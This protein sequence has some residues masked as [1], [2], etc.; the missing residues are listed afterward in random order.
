LSPTRKK[1]KLKLSIIPLGGV[2]EIGKNMMV[3]RYADKILVVDSGLMFPE[4]EMPGVDIV[5]PDMSY[6][7]ENR[8]NVL[9]VVLTHGHED[10]IGAL[11]Y[12]LRQ[13]NAP[14]YG[15]RLTLGLV[16]AKLDEHR[17]LDSTELHEIAAGE[18]IELGPFSIEFVRISHSIP[19]GVG[20]AIKTPVGTIVH[21]GDF[22][23]DLQSVESRRMDLARFSQLGDEGT[24]LLLSDCTNVEKKGFTASES[25]VADTFDEVFSKAP[26]RVIVA[27]F[28]SNIH[29]IQQVYDTAAKYDRKVAVVGRSMAQ[30]G[31]IAE[32]LGYLTVDPEAKLSI[33]EI[34]AT[35]PS[36]VAII[37]TGSQGE[38]LS[39]LSQMALDGHKKIKITEGD[40]VIISATPIP[41]NEALVMR[42]IN[43]L[44][45][46]GAHVVYEPNSPVHVSG[47]GN[48]ED[49]RLMLSL[50]RPKFVGPVHGEPRHT[51]KYREM[52]LSMGYA[53]ENMVALTLGD[54]LE[55][56]GDTMAITG[57][58]PDFGS[59]M[60]DGIGV[61]DVSDVVLRDRRHLAQ[62][63]IILAI[64]SINS[65]TGEVAAGPDII[66]RGFV[67]IEQAEELME[68]A[69]AVILDE[70]SSLSVEDAT[71]WTTV[72]SDVRSALA[73]FLYSRTRRRP[74]IVP[75]I[76]EV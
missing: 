21:T 16:T 69:K 5:I 18:T 3:Y 12:L 74:M 7:V 73:R 25:S 56:D 76:M 49:L 59:V 30:N 42:V 34:D 47:H 58:I 66:S 38:P 4:E 33:P 35:E 63:G 65:D 50:V 29:R 39:A 17:L 20:L 64:M 32:N 19:D 26:G 27:T 9:G 10:H 31:E 24:L 71:E 11:P 54:I 45:R 2:G 23:C 60:V 14:V 70:V 48:Q 53:P 62:D 61:G 13:V 52:A 75:V 40:T 1:K 6:L 28:A 55:T 67:Q 72:K 41:G 43:H 36:K 44:F 46:L 15:T 68:E 37:T 8:E 51:V 57:K 22:K